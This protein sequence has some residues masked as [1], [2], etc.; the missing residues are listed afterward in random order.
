MDTGHLGVVA[1][2]AA[3][4]AEAA[5]LVTSA[6]IGLG[7]R[8][9]NMHQFEATSFEVRSRSGHALAGVDG[10]SLDLPTPLQFRIH[11]G[12]MRLLVPSDAVLAAEKRRARGVNLGDLLRIASGQ[13]PS[14]KKLPQSR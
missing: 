14:G 7:K 3:T 1:V 13:A 4:G 2:N 6:T 9:P 5:K 11:P 10:E 8:N 12:G